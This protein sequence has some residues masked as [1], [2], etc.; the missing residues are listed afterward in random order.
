MIIVKKTFCLYLT[1]IMLG[2]SCVAMKNINSG[3]SQI[4]SNSEW[5]TQDNKTF[6]YRSW[7]KNENPKAI[8][9]AVHGLS[10]ASSDFEPLG[11]YFQNKDFNIYAVNERGQGND[12]DKNNRGDIK[13]YKNWI[14][15]LDNFTHLISEKNKNVPVFYYAESLGALITGNLLIEKKPQNIKG[16]IFASPVIKLEGEIPWWQNLIFRTMLLIKPDQKISFS[17]L[18]KND[19]VK[20]D[21]E[22]QRVTRNDQYQES[23]SKMP[24]Y[25]D[26]FTLRF[27]KNVG[28]M[29]ENINNHADK[30]N[31][32]LLIVYAGK[33]IFTKPQY[34][35]NFFQKIGSDNKE[36][37]L[38]PQSYHLLLHDSDKD[39]VLKNIEVWLNKSLEHL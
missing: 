9:I 21:K 32:N 39:E 4:I 6:K 33:D 34:I 1:L 30:I 29:I 23:L 16:V 25:I 2:Y 5:R 18:S 22:K 26:S 20:P 19:K 15:D 38:F 10:G 8:I 3:K 14:D 7:A 11:A 28:A 17:D 13:D 31:Q 37:I 27:L 12:P 24:H 36:K 35:D